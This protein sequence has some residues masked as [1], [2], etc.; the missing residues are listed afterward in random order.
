VTR[1]VPQRRRRG[2]PAPIARPFAVGLVGLI[3]IV[4]L[5]YA[6][7]AGRTP[8]SHPYELHAIFSNS[9]QLRSGSPVRIAGIGA[10]EVS[11]ISAGP[12]STADVGMRIDSSA[13]PI[14]S[15][16]TFTIRPRVFLEGGFY[17]D[18]DP[19][20]PGAPQLH[21]GATVPI[22]QTAVPVQLDQ[23]LSR[24]QLPVRQAL[25]RILAQAN[26]SLA[27]GGAAGLRRTIAALPPTLRDA[28]IVAEAAQGTRY[29]DVRRLLDSSERE[30]GQL[31][32]RDAELG[33]LVL[34]LDRT[35]TALVAHPGALGDGIHE[36]D[37]FLRAAPGALTALD[38]VVAPIDRFITKLR[39][40]ARLAPPILRQLHSLNRALRGIPSPSA[41]TGLLSGLRP[42]LR[43]TP[44]FSLLAR[45]LFPLAGPVVTCLRDN[46]MPTLRKPVDDGPLSSGRPVWQD[47]LHATVGL[48]SGAQN[49]DANGPWFRYLGSVG[50]S[51]VSTGSVPGLGE[52][53]GSTTQPIIGARPL[54]L[55]PGHAPPPFRPDAP[56]TKQAPPDLSATTGPAPAEPKAEHP[57]GLERAT[58]QRLFLHPKVRPAHAGEGG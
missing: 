55:G 6:A 47:F 24:L 53:L 5:V 2:A 18:L 14:H 50:P 40:T 4:V 16:A 17:V 38:T 22:A 32:S 54:W 29:G 48:A 10:G 43:N 46:V 1:L 42:L 28:A 31:A 51:T 7:F 25:R 9:S 44:K 13:L 21:S 8:F 58:I 34:S 49:F 12:G 41:E 30:T 52:L 35:S 23:I 36:L 27:R 20:S 19:G 39:P 37:R 45:G 33:D 56:C 11:S 3:A 57:K 26:A 15:D